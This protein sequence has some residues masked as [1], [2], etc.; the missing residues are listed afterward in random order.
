MLFT[1]EDLS[2]GY[3]NNLDGYIYAHFAIQMTLNIVVYAT[4]GQISADFDKFLGKNIDGINSSTIR[5]HIRVPV[6]EYI[7]GAGD[8]PDKTG[9]GA[10]SEIL[11]ATIG[12][13]SADS[14]TSRTDNLAAQM[15]M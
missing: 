5:T 10:L 14:T 1:S 13:R 12:G 7:S 11:R 4:H 8:A 2:E 3:K 15:I 9:T 6:S